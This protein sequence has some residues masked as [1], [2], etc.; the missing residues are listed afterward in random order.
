MLSARQ[1]HAARVMIGGDV[2]RVAAV[3]QPAGNGRSAV[4]HRADPTNRLGPAPAPGP[5]GWTGWT[6][7]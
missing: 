2:L 7:V 1:A 3:A 4:D 5:T 6:V